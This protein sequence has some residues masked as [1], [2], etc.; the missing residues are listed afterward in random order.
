[1]TVRLAQ[2]IGIEKAMEIGTRFGIYD[3]PPREFSIVLGAA[4]TTLLKLTN[5]YS[6]I[7]NGGKKNTPSLIE[8]ID[9]RHGKTIYRRD[10]REC[11]LCKVES[12][13]SMASL[14]KSVLPPL[15]EDNREQL[16]DPRVVYQLT[17]MLQGVTLRGTAARAN[18]ELKKIVA[19]K[20]GTTN[21]SKDTWFIGY[22]PDL[23][24]GVF[25]G[26]DKPRTM[27]KK[28]T[29][30]SVA[31]PAF[32]DFMKVALAD[33]PNQ[34]F[35]V[36]RGIRLSKVDLK[37][38]L[39]PIGFGDEKIIEEAYISGGP[40]FI[41]GNGVDPK[42]VGTGGDE[43]TP[44]PPLTSPTPKEDKQAPPVVGTGALY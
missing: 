39:P 37:S 19:G 20:T 6:S 30:S 10:N 26:Y 12:V 13:E 43:N 27:G 5:A 14:D 40:I 34:P 2:I 22:S 9:D 3:N 15:P 7:A 4:E 42:T 38:G 25:V 18:V 1:M 36:P 11:L 32:I 41:P 35:R 23:V 28:E 21:D 24:A 8:R 17:S 16:A 44:Y 29:G 31:L 33:K